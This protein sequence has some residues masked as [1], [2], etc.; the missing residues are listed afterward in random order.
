MINN[1][2]RLMFFIL[3]STVLIS[4][5][6]FV[7]AQESK[8]NVPDNAFT[9]FLDSFFAP[10]GFEQTIGGWI[11]GLI[12]ALI[13]FVIM[14]DVFQLVLPFSDW[15]NWVIASGFGITAIVLGV[16]KYMAGYTL[17]VG[18]AIFGGAVGA[19]LIIIGVLGLLALIS[20]F[21]GGNKVVNALKKI[22]V[23]RKNQ[24]KEL[25]AIEAAGDIHAVEKE[26]EEISKGHK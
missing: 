18:S 19:S 25:D 2:K 7:A 12:A 3:L 16:T 26:T 24:R 22:K 11:I 14:L 20:L 17:S 10:A 5:L 1:K 15:V 4:V 21:F 6:P 23:R 13:V 8:I 9:R